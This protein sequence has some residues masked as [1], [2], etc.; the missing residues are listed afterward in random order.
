MSDRDGTSKREAVFDVVCS[1]PGAGPSDVADELGLHP[2]T[3]EYHLRRLDEN[4]RVVLETVGRR[5]CFYPEG[6]GWCRCSRAAHARLTQA[7]RTMLRAALDRGLVSRRQVVSRG[8][9]RSAVRWALKQLR[10][11]GVLE[12]DGWGIYVLDEDKRDC[13]LAA[14]NERPCA[15]CNEDQDL[16]ATKSPSPSGRIVASSRESSSAS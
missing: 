7:G 8:H 4:G 14:L 2:S 13:A 15:A 12:R 11:I 3:A 16:R 10:E 9:S 1:S 5:R 6:E